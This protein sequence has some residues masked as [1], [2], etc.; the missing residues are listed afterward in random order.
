MW[1]LLSANFLRL[2]KSRL[3]WG[4]L[5]LSFGMGVG[6][7]LNYYQMSRYESI[8]LEGAFF[9]FPMLCSLISAV[10]IPLFFGREYSDRTIRNKVT[11][12]HSRL[13]IYGANLIAGT[14]A[15][16]L[17]GAAYMAAVAVVGMPLIGP[18]KMDAKL[19]A[20]VILGSLA[21]VAA[22][23]ALFTLIAMV[24]SRKTV[25]AVICILGTFIL[26]AASIYMRSRL[27]APEYYTDYSMTAD[28]TVVWGGVV[29]NPQYLSGAQRAVCE[30]VHDLL[31]SSQAVQYASQQTQDLCL[32]P[33]Y[34][35]AVIV[36]S[37]GAG[38]ALFRRKDL[39]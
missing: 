5:A 22:F 24:C 7:A 26:F 36:L 28:G 19:A 15:S 21:A 8:T 38:T 11:A 4:A 17:F 6:M 34:S 35:L 12:G 37:T 9:V 31:P 27:E 20:L 29:A 16:L 32:M 10:F 13:R 25:S 2:K 30:F 18:I 33:L 14:A 1:N 39:R 23:C 3:F